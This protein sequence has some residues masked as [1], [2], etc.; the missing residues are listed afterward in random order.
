MLPALKSGAQFSCACWNSKTSVGSQTDLLLLH[1]CQSQSAGQSFAKI[2]KDLCFVVSGF[3]TQSARQLLLSSSTISELKG[4]NSLSSAAWQHKVRQGWSG[5]FVVLTPSSTEE[6][7]DWLPNGAPTNL[8][9]SQLAALLRCISDLCLPRAVGLCMHCRSIT[10]LCCHFMCHGCLVMTPRTVACAR[11][12]YLS[13]LLLTLHRPISFLHSRCR[14]RTCNTG[15]RL[16]CRL[17]P[18]TTVLPAD[19]LEWP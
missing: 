1:V 9:F 5:D 10:R 3:A 7:P 14:Q 2:E 17:T 18:Q 13:L 6:G 4:I 19:A 8:A 15:S 12:C 16:S 11:L